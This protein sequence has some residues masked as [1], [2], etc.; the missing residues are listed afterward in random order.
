VI[1]CSSVCFG[2]WLCEY[3]YV[4]RSGA[5]AIFI[6]RFGGG[7]HGGRFG[8]DSMLAASVPVDLTAISACR[9]LVRSPPQSCK[10]FSLCFNSHWLPVTPRDMLATCAVPQKESKSTT[11]SG[12]RATSG[13][14]L[15]HPAQAGG[16][17]S[18]A[19]LKS[20]RVERPR[21]FHP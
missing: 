1:V 11:M 15:G 4:Y 14:L 7:F 6:D 20:E 10:I 8:G 17:L 16:H 5:A 13:G 2:S 21:R 12:L 18:A 9:V 3:S 19:G